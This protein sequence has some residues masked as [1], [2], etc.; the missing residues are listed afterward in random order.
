MSFAKRYN[1]VFFIFCFSILTG[2]KWKPENTY[3]KKL[4]VCTTSIISDLVKQLVKER[5]NVKTLMG[6]GVDP[7][8]YE[9][10]PSDVRALANAHVIIYN[11]VHLEGKMTDLF[12]RMGNEKI[13]FSFS[14]GMPKKGL[15]KVNSHTYDPH[16]WF[17]PLLWL[18]GVKGC[19]NQLIKVFPRDKD[20]F[21]ENYKNI[22]NQLIMLN[23][24]LKDKI[25][26]VDKSQRVLITSHDAF[27]Y[28]G[29]SFGVEVLAIQGISTVSEPG[30]KDISNL[31]KLIADR[32]IKAIFVESS[33]S[34]K[35]ISA[36]VEGC[37]SRGHIVKI[38]GTLYSDALGD[39]KS[40]AN[41]YVGMMRK[42]VNTI[43]YALKN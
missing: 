37:K 24:D 43:V 41:S 6:P 2:C 14:S 17:D 29:R 10:K 33:V 31:I 22:E 28:F 26:T 34:A 16:V 9:A 4:I 11:G 27:H 5:Y 38:G 36:V 12:Q 13:L 21:I 42:N 23:K 8:M 15:I 25:N 39:D 35:S 3:D 40:G 30:I 18:N 20:F 7:H 19:V 32:K 1:L